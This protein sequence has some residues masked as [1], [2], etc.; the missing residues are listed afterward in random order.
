[1]MYKPF[2][3]WLKPFVLLLAVV[4]MAHATCT[5]SCV[6]PHN[7]KAPPQSNSQAPGNCHHSKAPDPTDHK[8]SENS[9]TCSLPQIS[10]DRPTTTAQDFK[11][12]PAALPAFVVTFSAELG[13]MVGLH[14]VY[15]FQFHV[16][17]PGTNVLRI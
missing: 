11:P 17:A 14:E 1:M 9:S 3:Y 12:L 13:G 8:E 10:G 2:M 5:V 6:L 4:V 15:G 16:S 7:G